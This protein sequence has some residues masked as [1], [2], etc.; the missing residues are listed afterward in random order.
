[1]SIRK[2]TE[3]REAERAASKLAEQREKLFLVSDGGAEERPIEVVSASLVEPK[4]LAVS[5]PAC[6]GALKLV[7]HDAVARGPLT[8]RAARMQ[9]ARCGVRRT[10]W[11]HVVRP[12][13][14]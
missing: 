9:C 5:C 3:R 7:S 12:R 13:P 11:F 4:A 14:N 1:M 10:I 6:D 2:R 8:L